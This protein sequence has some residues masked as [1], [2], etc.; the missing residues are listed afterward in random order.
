MTNYTRFSQPTAAEVE[1]RKTVNELKRVAT[2]TAECCRREC[3][4]ES[5]GGMMKRAPRRV[6]ANDAA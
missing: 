6:R 3:D 4:A 5:E 2:A 1:A